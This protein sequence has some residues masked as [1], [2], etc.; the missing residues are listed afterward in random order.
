VKRDVHSPKISWMF[1]TDILPSYITGI[2]FQGLR[3][4]PA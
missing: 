1:S 2:L 3:T 4:Y